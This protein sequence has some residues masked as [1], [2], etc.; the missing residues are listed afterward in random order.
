LSNVVVVG[1][2][3]KLQKLGSETETTVDK[4]DDKALIEIVTISSKKFRMR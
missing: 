3:P 4:K 2:T 1:I